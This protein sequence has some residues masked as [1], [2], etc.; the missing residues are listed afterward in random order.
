R[1]LLRLRRR[2]PQ[3][4]RRRFFMGEYDRAHGLHDIAWFR[5]DGE[6]MQDG[7]WHDAERRAL[8]VCLDGQAPTSGLQQ[9]VR[10]DTLVL[11]FN[12]GH[13]DEGFRL[14]PHLRLVRPLLSSAETPPE[15][16]DDV[17][18]LPPRSLAVL[19]SRAPAGD[20]AAPG[21]HRVDTGG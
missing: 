6:P 17:W 1:R 20:D 11:L 9:A 14:P 7:D 12:A 16:Q 4:R 8:V 15:P 2:Y 3:L 19:A 21:H 10:S 18:T 13:A 5:P